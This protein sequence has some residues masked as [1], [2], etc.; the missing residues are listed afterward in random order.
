MPLTDL[1]R[2]TLAVKRCQE[3]GTVPS[4]CHSKDL[5]MID[6][7]AEYPCFVAVMIVGTGTSIG[8]ISGY[9]ATR[10]LDAITLRCVPPS[11]ALKSE[12][13]SAKKDAYLTVMWKWHEASEIA[14]LLRR[15]RDG[16]VQLV[17]GGLGCDAVE[18]TEPFVSLTEITNSITASTWVG[19][20][21]GPAQV[22]R[23]IGDEIAWSESPPPSSRE[24]AEPDTVDQTKPPGFP[25]WTRPAVVPAGPGEG[26]G[27][28]G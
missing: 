9:A 5:Y 26:N 16:T 22:L 10:I 1:V 13:G 17:G 21:Y 15:H 11:E 8:R 12:L 2:C 25:V 27:H 6:Q 28:V 18:L 20:E 3:Y 4:P 19:L 7:Y 14:V 24:V 23:W